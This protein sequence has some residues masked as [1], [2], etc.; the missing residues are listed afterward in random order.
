MI[1][2]LKKLIERRK[3]EVTVL[4]F[5]DDNPHQ[6]ET[7]TIHPGKFFLM[8]GGITAGVVLLIMLIFFV[9]PLGTWIFNKEDRAVRASV[10]EISERVEALKDSLEAR[11]NQMHEI[12]QIIRNSAD[13]TF[14]IQSTEAWQTM[15]GEEDAPA[16]RSSMTV[17]LA[18][19]SNIPSLHSDQIVFSEIFSGDIM[20]PAEPPVRGTLTNPYKPDEGHFGIDIAASRGADVRT[21][22]N[23]VVISSDWTFNNGYVMHILHGN[24]IISAYKHF[25]EVFVTS[26]QVVRKGEL[27]GKVGET[28]LLASG[29]HIHFELWKDGSSLDPE[30]YINLY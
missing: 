16:D 24:G 12:Q 27:I 23:G 25:S 20:F 17:Q 2:F 11:D 1:T 8:F 29:P 18:D 19:Q 26:G 5:D 10:I 14:D 3:E 22:A 6:Q 28:G 9:T 21:V 13:T 4:L 30:L 7:Y 15:Y